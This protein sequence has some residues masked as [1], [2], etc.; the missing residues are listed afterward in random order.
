MGAQ[1]PTKNVFWKGNDGKVWVNGDDGVNTAGSWDDNTRSYWGD[2]GFAMLPDQ[3]VQNYNVSPPPVPD[4]PL[5][6]TRTSSAS[7]EGTA[8]S[9]N[10]E[11][12]DYLNNQESLY[13]MLKGSLG[14][15]FESGMSKLEQS[16]TKA[17][18]DATDAQGRAMRNYGMQKESSARGK[19]QAIGQVD[20]NAN[21]LYN[22]VKRIIGM[23]SG[24]GSSAYRQ[25][26][27]NAVARQ[28]SQ[29]RGSVMSR[30]GE[31]DRNIDIA[32]GDTQTDFQKILEEIAQ[33]RRESEESL[34]SGVGIQEQ[35]ITQSL[36]EIAAAKAGLLGGSQ[37][38]AM[39]PYQDRYAGIQG[40]LDALPSRFMSNYTPRALNTSAPKLSDYLVDRQ[41][42][43]SSRATGQ[44][45]YSPYAAFLNKD[46][47]E[48]A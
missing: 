48:L 21:N 2:R 37:L 18:N 13:N 19:Q 7:T 20:S 22:S 29:Q 46:E 45:Q 11:D 5:M 39:K 25:A 24:S 35:G 15:T 41:A 44:T 1:A 16:K 8:P 23:A 33:K 27:P 42:I 3:T 12:M 9:Y 47:E 36:A 32:Q 26:A 38:D 34:R 31:N 40:E 4:S 6:S 14:K 10:Q 28:A 17:D 30:F 43:N